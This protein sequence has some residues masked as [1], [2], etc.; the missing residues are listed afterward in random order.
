LEVQL[1]RTF[2]ATFTDVRRAGAMR[3]KDKH[4]PQKKS[5]RA[6]VHSTRCPTRFRS[7]LAGRAKEARGDIDDDVSTAEVGDEK[8][9]SDVMA[10]VIEGLTIKRHAP[11]CSHLAN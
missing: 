10:D 11:S 5:R 6:R 4:G 7:Q 9:A 2:A 3:D 8:D 1:F